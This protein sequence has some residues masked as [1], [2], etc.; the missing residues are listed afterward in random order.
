MHT[1]IFR[2]YILKQNLIVSR[3]L[4]ICSIFLYNH[5]KMFVFLHS[6][7]YISI[8]YITDND[9]ICTQHLFAY[10]ADA[11]ISVAIRSISLRSFICINLCMFVSWTRS[12]YRCGAVVVIYKFC[13][14]TMQFNM[15]CRGYVCVVNISHTIPN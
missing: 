9:V 1:Q 2:P 14:R 6:K 7:D 8:N 4:D 13:I 5:L 11:L 15:T 10:I 3:T 12:C